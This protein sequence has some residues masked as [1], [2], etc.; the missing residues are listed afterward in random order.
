MRENNPELTKELSRHAGSTMVGKAPPYPINTY[1]ELV[2]QVAHLS[3][4]NK[5]N[6]LFFR[7]QTQDF[8]NKAGVSTFYPSIYREENLSQR[9]IVYR[10]EILD[11]AS[12]QLR[13]LFSKNKIDGHADVGRKRYIQWSILQHYGVCNT[14][15]L[16]FTHSL[17]V[18][19]SFA[20]QDK[21]REIVFV[22]VFGLPYITNRISINS[23]HDIINIRLLS[24]CPP[25]ALRPFFQEGYLAGTS[26]VTNDYESKSEL[27]FNRRLVAKFA[28]PNTKKFWGSGLSKIPDS[29]LYPQ[30]DSI[31]Q[32]CKSIETTIQTGIHPGAIGE[33]LA[34][35]V[36]LEQ[37]L[38]Q[39]VKGQEARPV[40]VREA[41]QR[42]LKAEMITYDQAYQIDEFRRFRNIL[43]HEPRRIETNDITTYLQNLRDFHKNFRWANTIIPY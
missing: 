14:P 39:K 31:E 26:D 35:W 41:V 11:H 6:L 9:E 24:I 23:E 3:Y 18:A 2:E 16:D 30:N 43:V 25:D 13:E 10:F 29:M 19:C 22:Y 12:R 40:S 36:Q 32:L 1:R 21:T 28:I 37:T 17:R 38:L 20:Q 42:L 15:L 7:G 34:E 27:D 33:F 5:D 8:H 4:L